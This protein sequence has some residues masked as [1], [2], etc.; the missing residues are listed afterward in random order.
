MV[1]GSFKRGKF[2][3]HPSNWVAGRHGVVHI[4]KHGKGFVVAYQAYP[5]DDKFAEKV[6]ALQEAKELAG[7][8]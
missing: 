1:K 6:K 3:V 5:G 4:W 2:F 8:T 7:M